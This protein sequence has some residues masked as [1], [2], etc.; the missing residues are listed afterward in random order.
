M[1][2]V[3]EHEVVVVGGGQAGLTL[4]YFLRR[5]GR[6]SRSSKRPT[7]PPPPGGRGGPTL[8]VLLR[9]LALFVG[10]FVVAVLVPE[11]RGVLMA[12]CGL[13]TR[14]LH[15]SVCFF[16]LI[17]MTNL[18]RSDVSLAVSPELPRSGRAARA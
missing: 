5:Q 14:L 11:P 16:T 2:P 9:Q 17:H 1:R 8:A 18:P 12:L 4:G 3:A 13:V 15:P 6:R 7:R 10:A